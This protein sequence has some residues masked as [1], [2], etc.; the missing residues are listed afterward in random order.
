MP[1]VDDLTR[2]QISKINQ[3]IVEYAESIEY[4][5][6]LRKEGDQKIQSMQYMGGMGGNIGGLSMIISS[7]DDIS[8]AEKHEKEATRKLNE[9]LN[10]VFKSGTRNVIAYRN[11]WLAQYYSQANSHPKSIEYLTSALRDLDVSELITLNEKFPWD[12][13]AFNLMLTGSCTSKSGIE[14]V[15]NLLFRFSTDTTLFNS[16]SLTKMV[17]YKSLQTITTFAALTADPGLIKSAIDVSLN[18]IIR[19]LRSTDV[20]RSESAAIEIATVLKKICTI[21]PVQIDKIFRIIAES[22]EDF[23]NKTVASKF[24]LVTYEMLDKVK[25]NHPELNFDKYAEKVYSNPIYTLDDLIEMI[26]ISEISDKHQLNIVARLFFAKNPSSEKLGELIRVCIAKGISPDGLQLSEVDKNT[27]INAIYQNS[28]SPVFDNLTLNQASINARLN[29]VKL[30]KED[31]EKFGWVKITTATSKMEIEKAYEISIAVTENMKDSSLAFLLINIA[32]KNETIYNLPKEKV[33]SWFNALSDGD[34]MRLMNHLAVDNSGYLNQIISSNPKLLK[35]IANG[36]AQ[37][38]F[39]KDLKEIFIHKFETYEW[40]SN[41]DLR[42]DELIIFFHNFT[43]SEL[44]SIL[45]H[46]HKDVDRLQSAQ[47]SVLL[48]VELIQ[49]IN[50]ILDAFR[51]GKSVN[52]LPDIKKLRYLIVEYMDAYSTNLDSKNKEARLQDE[53]QLRQFL[54]E[55]DLSELFTLIKDLVRGY[56]FEKRNDIDDYQYFAEKLTDGIIQTLFTAQREAEEIKS[57][58]L[59]KVTSNDDVASRFLTSGSILYM[60]ITG[61]RRSPFYELKKL[62]ENNVESKFKSVADKLIPAMVCNIDNYDKGD[63]YTLKQLIDLSGNRNLIN[64]VAIEL[65]HARTQE[66][67]GLNKKINSILVGDNPQ[68]EQNQILKS[69]YISRIEYLVND[70][71]SKRGQVLA[72]FD[73]TLSLDIYEDFMKS[74]PEEIVT[75][76]LSQYAI[77]HVGANATPDQIIKLSGETILFY[78][79]DIAKTPTLRTMQDALG[80]AHFNELFQK[81]DYS[82]KQDIIN[83]L[84]SLDISSF[85]EDQLREYGNV[86]VGLL[87]NPVN[88]L[89]YLDPDQLYRLNQ[90]LTELKETHKW[91]DK[92]E[93]TWLGKFGLIGLSDWISDIF[94]LNKLEHELKRLTNIN[95]QVALGMYLNIE[96]LDPDT[97]S[98]CERAL[99]IRILEDINA[100]RNN[101]Y[102]NL[103]NDYI[104]GPI[105]SEMIF[106]NIDLDRDADLITEKTKS[107]LI[108]A[109][110]R[111]DT[112][113]PK[114]IK[115]L[116][117]NTKTEDVIDIIDR[118]K[119]KCNNLKKSADSA[120]LKGK[121]LLS[122]ASSVID[123]DKKLSLESE[124]N[125]SIKKSEELI[126]KSKKASETAISLLITVLSNE[127][128]LTNLKQNYRLLNKAVGKWSVDEC[129]H[130]AER[131]FGNASDT[132]LAYMF[133][134]KDFVS[135]MQETKSLDTYIRRLNLDNVSVSYIKKILPEVVVALF[136]DTNALT[137]LNSLPSD[138]IQSLIGQLNKNNVDDIYNYWKNIDGGKNVQSLCLLFLSNKS[139][140]HRLIEENA[141]DTYLQGLH[142]TSL[143]PDKIKT[144]TYKARVALLKNPSLLKSFDKMKSDTFSALVHDF[145]ST[146]LIGTSDIKDIVDSWSKNPNEFALFPKNLLLAILNNRQFVK[147][148]ISQGAI[149]NYLKHPNLDIISLSPSE[150]TQ[151]N[152]H[153]RAEIFKDLSLLANWKHTAN[154]ALLL[155]LISGFGR[156]ES[157]FIPVS[158][159]EDHV[160]YQKIFDS[161]KSIEPVSDESI[162]LELLG[163]SFLEDVSNHTFALKLLFINR[164][165]RVIE[166]LYKHSDD[167]YKSLMAVS[168]LSEFRPRGFL[169][170]ESIR[171]LSNNEYDKLVRCAIMPDGKTYISN[172]LLELKEIDI[173]IDYASRNWDHILTNAN[174]EFLSAVLSC[175][176][177]IN[178]LRPSQVQ[179]GIVKAAQLN[180]PPSALITAIKAE[181]SYNRTNSIKT[182]KLLI[183]IPNYFKS[184]PVTDLAPDE[185]KAI[186]T[187]TGLYCSSMEN[188]ANALNSAFILVQ[189][190]KNNAYVQEAIVDGIFHD[191]RLFPEL[192]RQAEQN[193]QRNSPS[194]F[195]IKHKLERISPKD[196]AR[197]LYDTD[198]ANENFHNLIIKKQLPLRPSLKAVAQPLLD[199]QIW[200]ERNALWRGISWLSW[201]ITGMPKSRGYTDEI[202][203][204]ER[205]SITPPPSTRTKSS[206]SDTAPEQVSGGSRKDISIAF[207]N[208]RPK[209]SKAIKQVYAESA[210]LS[211]SQNVKAEAN[212]EDIKEKTTTFKTSVIDKASSTF[213]K[214][215]K[216]LDKLI[217]LKEKNGKKDYE[218]LKLKGLLESIESSTKNFNLELFE[219][220]GNAMPS[221]TQVVKLKIAMDEYLKYIPSIDK[222][223]RDKYIYKNFLAGIDDFYKYLQSIP[224]YNALIKLEEGIQQL[225]LEQIKLKQ[226]TSQYQL[227]QHKIDGL[228]DIQ[229]SIL[230][231]GENNI[232]DIIANTRANPKFKDL[233]SG[234]HSRTTAI[235]TEVTAIL[236]DKTLPHPPEP[237]FS[238]PEFVPAASK[239]SP[240]ISLN[241]F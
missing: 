173:V 153:A 145:S 9:I 16:D 182:S 162:E 192:C 207:E 238:I 78:L 115:F 111:S 27:L 82:Y 190:N 137:K 97:K 14:A 31:V 221:I 113:S 57:S 147:E 208:S 85:N 46:Y 108:K 231:P 106:R 127:Q 200:S 2:D 34:L 65:F 114:Q 146:A 193:T 119:E 181:S 150:L 116:T 107:I 154:D 132:F 3:A 138:K 219:I 26:K 235:I 142:I 228:R 214:Q 131:L 168:L 90:K 18:L 210:Q 136:K 175:P 40:V 92:R 225:E 35:K 118:F 101:S 189:D 17:D 70:Q 21:D 186:Q 188:R 206:Q 80:G 199:R 83:K 204:F 179:A 89:V 15:I 212:I 159:L 25:L 172:P 112:L 37:I 94:K 241:T 39:N 52:D 1:L 77:K 93:K 6:R 191:S 129:L 141:L 28:L 117:I 164:P 69:T 56:D 139:V 11:Y 123:E 239:Q 229:N 185:L 184:L 217:K 125:K 72:I 76:I 104:Y 79:D 102:I 128:H 155:A 73:A 218:N 148:L 62:Q 209:S 29:F 203:K 126:E 178:K 226:T 58:D 121:K 45:K 13:K 103:C 84:I 42:Q 71:R 8:K 174:V 95:D 144:V 194:L 41:L 20:E 33:N 213:T 91:I 24:A 198:L 140:V 216:L 163:E 63:S 122:E 205:Q 51:R 224:L 88:V 130:I 220:P 169:L 134:R 43:G 237:G 240:T 197:Q 149:Y 166:H 30:L 99:S 53:E 233:D 60:A 55:S 160:I 230:N 195:I 59:L 109:F 66:I 120:N 133:S 96:S 44:N 75:F 64:K 68:S 48:N 98:E 50:T 223:M 67:D 105:F 81:T 100:G 22:G 202:K 38:P 36:S 49:S 157:G 143:H 10:T 180:M 211:V 152:K 124:G 32:I 187:L 165:E 171:A 201:S 236:K 177:I 196:F 135:S 158:F 183:N 54:K 61:S 4:A 156:D 47:L 234:Y 167:A 227:K 19:Y 74:M 176:T 86:L 7:S 12:K 87:E 232:E 151:I 170:R 161:W 222:E 5:N 215:L 110:I 23:V